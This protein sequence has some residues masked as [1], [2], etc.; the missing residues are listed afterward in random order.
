MRKALVG[1]LATFRKSRS[2]QLTEEWNEDGIKQ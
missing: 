2:V 1:A